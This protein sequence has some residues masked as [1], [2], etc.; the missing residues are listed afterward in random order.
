M[1]C[2]YRKKT[3]THEYY[4]DT[5]VTE[6]FMPCYEEACPYYNPEQRHGDI[7]VWASCQRTIKGKEKDIDD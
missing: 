3:T 7:I 5:T 1:L 6:E 2:P 4:G